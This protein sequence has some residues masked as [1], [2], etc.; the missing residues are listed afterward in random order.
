MSSISSVN[1]DPWR[2]HRRRRR[3]FAAQPG[4]VTGLL[5][6]NGAEKSTNMRNICGLTSAT[7]G[8]VAGR[9]LRG[10]A[11]PGG[12]GR[13]NARC[14]RAAR[15]SHRPRDPDDRPAVHRPPTAAGRAARCCASTT[16]PRTPEDDTTSGQSPRHVRSN[17]PPGRGRRAPGSGPDRT[18]A[19]P[20]WCSSHQ[21]PRRFPSTDP[22]H[23]SGRQG[24]NPAG[25]TGGM[26]DSGTPPAH[27]NVAI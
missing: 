23:G 10:H 1:Q 18:G 7:G 11:N 21:L 8:T 17:S 14:V 22:H 24:S 6:P 13:R 19:Y 16:G 20:H 27:R 25:C 9:Q 5:G 4:C 12:R 2:L 26:Q 3:R 15:R